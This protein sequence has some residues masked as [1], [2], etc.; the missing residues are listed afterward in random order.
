MNRALNGY[1]GR[2]VFLLVGELDDEHRLMNEFPVRVLDGRI[3]RSPVPGERLAPTPKLILNSAYVFVIEH[4]RALRVTARGSHDKIRRF[5][6]N[7]GNMFYM[8][9][10]DYREQLNLR[11]VA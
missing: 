6:S 11:K 2:P 1:V 9:V 10:K 5:P 8:D 4:G 7:R 3:Q